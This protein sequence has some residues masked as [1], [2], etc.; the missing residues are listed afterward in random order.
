M[1][2]DTGGRKNVLKRKCTVAN[3]LNCMHPTMC[4]KNNGS[5][6]IFTIPGRNV[7]FSNMLYVRG[8]VKNISIFLIMI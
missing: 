7:D 3:N 4:N 2:I 8:A 6:D 1:G 5:F